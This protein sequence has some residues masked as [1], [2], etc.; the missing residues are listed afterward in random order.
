MQ[1]NG[2]RHTLLGWLLAFVVAAVAMIGSAA[3]APPDIPLKSSYPAVD[4]TDIWYKAS[5]PGKGVQLVQTGSFVF[6]TV[7]IYGPDRKPTWVTGELTSPAL[8]SNTFTGPLYV[9]TGP[10]FGGT[11]DQGL[12]TQRQAGTMTFVI[13]TFDTGM[14]TYSVDGVTVSDAVQRQPLTLDDY[15]GIYFALFTQTVT[16]CQTPSGNGSLTT[17][18]GVQIIQGATK[19]DGTA[20]MT[21]QTQ[22]L[23]PVG[24]GNTCNFSGTY[25]Q[26]GRSGRFQGSY[27]CKAGEV[28][29]GAMAE[30]NNHVHQFNARIRLVSTNNGCTTTG[31][32]TG[33]IPD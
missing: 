21:L 2:V 22:Q 4:V 8:G 30:M 7:Y 29:N 13:Q 16:G 5:Q 24:D 12:V 27:V 23:S 19:P 9:N 26:L 15:N 3:G 25:S 11:W 32:I 10:Y 14:L 6:A 31:R 28:G 18:L 17:L 33:L 20:T 1:A